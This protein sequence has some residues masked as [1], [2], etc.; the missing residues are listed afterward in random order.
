M[1]KDYYCR[2][3]QAVI[4]KLQSIMHAREKAGYDK[5]PVGARIIRRAH[6]ASSTRRQ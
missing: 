6:S 5:L 4:R 2:S 1:H 3:A